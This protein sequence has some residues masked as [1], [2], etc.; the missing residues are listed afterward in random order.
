MRKRP[1]RSSGKWFGGIE[2]RQTVRRRKPK[3]A[4]P[5]P[6]A[7]ASERIKMAQSEAAAR[8]EMQGESVAGKVLATAKTLVA[9]IQ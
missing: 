7:A 1:G 3:P 5:R 2:Q 4:I 6:C 8:Q 9:K